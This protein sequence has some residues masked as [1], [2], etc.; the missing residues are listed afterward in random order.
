MQYSHIRVKSLEEKHA[1]LKFLLEIIP[2]LLIISFFP[3]LV[4]SFWLET[5]FYWSILLFTLAGLLLIIR[6]LA[7]RYETGLDFRARDLRL[8]FKED[9]VKAFR[10]EIVEAVEARK[11]AVKNLEQLLEKEGLTPSELRELK[12]AIAWYKKDIDYWKKEILPKVEE[13]E[14]HFSNPDY[15]LTLLDIL[16]YQRRKEVWDVHLQEFKRGTRRI[17]LIV[18]NGEGR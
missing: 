15:K 17:E 8:A 16:D 10:E 1:G 11:Q 2:L 9:E 3:L 18:T 4:L 12:R 6:N 7:V 14:R 13:R 5:T